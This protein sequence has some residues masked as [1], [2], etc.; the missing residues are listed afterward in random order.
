MGP[1][2]NLIMPT[3]LASFTPQTLATGIMPSVGSFDSFVLSTTVEATFSSLRYATGLP[4]SVARFAEYA[5]VIDQ[6]IGVNSGLYATLYADNSAVQ[7]VP[8]ARAVRPPAAKREIV[9]TRTNVA[10]SDLVPIDAMTGFGGTT[11]EEREFGLAAYH[12]VALCRDGGNKWQGFTLLR[13][14]GYAATGSEGTA[15]A[16]IVRQG[17]LSLNGGIYSVNDAFV[18]ALQRFIKPSTA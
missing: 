2:N 15:L 14:M 9:L 13:F 5:E 10:P 8:L 18:Q 7:L 3:T 11:Q 6:A 1:V 17:L 4:G 16:R 12:V